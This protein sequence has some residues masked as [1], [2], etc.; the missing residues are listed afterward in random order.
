MSPQRSSPPCLV[1][2]G[3]S[4]GVGKT[5]LCCGIIRAFQRRGLAVAPFKCGPDYLDPSYLSRAAKRR[6]H[7]LDSWMMG[8]EALRSTFVRTSADADL[9]LVEGVMGIFDGAV[10]TNEAGSTAQV[11]KWLGSPAIL[12]VDAGGMARSVAAVV[13]GFQDYDPELWLRGVICNRVGSPRHLDLLRQALGEAPSCIVGGLP[14]KLD[15][16]FS[17]RHL[18]LL[19]AR[20]QVVQEEIFD[21]LA[22]LVEH[23]IDLDALLE[24]ARQA[25]EL[26]AAPASTPLDP[27]AARCRIGIA[28]D[29]AFSFYYDENLD[30]LRAQGAELVE[31][32]PLHDLQ[33]PAV[34]GLYFGG[35]YPELHAQVLHENHSMRRDVA[36][37][38]ANDRPVYAECGGLMYLCQGIEGLDGRRCEMVGAL[39]GWATLCDRIQALGYTEVCTTRDSLLGP[40]G[41]RYRGHQFRYSKLQAVGEKVDCV[42]ELHRRRDGATQTEGYV[43][44]SALGSYVHGHWASNPGIARNFVQACLQPSS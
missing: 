39:P 33:L 37:F 20:T 1:L 38:I 13:K 10:P 9:A 23:W 30:L 8:Q 42:F 32:S 41:T 28:Q 35:G 17:G 12:V 22:E 7:N 16:T 3:V 11:A 44:R 5:T 18:G 15:C 26:P 2:G 14:K 24:M 21:R 40:A 34:D 36:A 6:A 29:E 27:A 25:R 43:E 4:S 19:E 31:F